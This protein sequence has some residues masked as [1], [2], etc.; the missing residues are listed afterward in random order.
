[1]IYTGA[2]ARR[3]SLAPSQSLALPVLFALFGLIMG[4]WAGRIPALRDGVQASHS[5]LSLILLC[6]GLGALASF[7]F[8]SWMMAN[9]GGR[10]T[11]FYSGLALLAVL[12]AI[13]NAPTVPLLMLAVLSL[14]ITAS[15]FD[16]SINSVAAKYEKTTGKSELSKL[17][18]W[19]CGGG[20]SGATLGSFMG[21][22][23]INPSMQFLM[24]AV[25]LVFVLKIGYELLEADEAGEK[26]EKKVF[27]LP[28]GPL[29]L[30]G[31]LG[32]FGSVA[33]GSIADWSGVFLKD[34]FGVDDGF[35]P[36]ALTA[37]SVMM[38]VTRLMGDQ[39]KGKYS[40]RK[41]LSCGATIAAAGLL[42]ATFAPDPYL[43]LAGFAVAG[44]GLALVFPFVFSAAGQQGPMALAGVATMAYS[45]TLMGPPVIG[46]L[47]H[48]FGMQTAIGFIGLLSIIIA[49]IAS[50]TTM[51][52]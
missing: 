33:E 42:F 11:L 20:L 10:K 39:L 16:V 29:A 37:F 46:G 52:K 34:H 41:L 1:M 17:H 24:I 30:L 28:R 49:L 12:L 51:L 27:C 4:S 25:P 36:L 47:A 8:S 22:M 35:A 9:F 43:A 38:L 45:G 14:G 44:L 48:G 7:P 26:I 3:L 6:G 31:A 50:R 21:S 5:S 23:K 13:G 15:C 40:A 18:A 2:P 32:F 19:G